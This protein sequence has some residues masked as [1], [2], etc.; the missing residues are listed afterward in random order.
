MLPGG[1]S[2][3]SLTAI[4]W[5]I[6][7]GRREP[8]C[9][10]FSMIR[11][12]YHLLAA[13]ISLTTL[14]AAQTL[15]PTKT[16]TLH[17]SKQTRSETV[18]A[19]TPDQALLAL[20]PQ[21]Q[22]RWKL[23]RLTGWNTSS[24]K[25]EAL[26][27]D[28]F[29]EEQRHTWGAGIGA[30]LIVSPDGHYVVTRIQTE[31]PGMLS[32]ARRNTDAIIHVVDLQTFKSVLT[33]ETTEPL[34]AGSIWS[35]TPEGNLISEIG[36]GNQ[37]KGRIDSISETA[38]ALSLPNLQASLTCHY[39]ENYGA[40]ETIG[41]ST[42]R[43]V[44]I[45]DVSQNC[46]ALMTLAKASDLKGLYHSNSTVT[47]VSKQLDFHPSGVS[48]TWNNQCGILDVSKQEKFVLYECVTGHQTWYDTV[49]STSRSYS[50]LSV[51]EAKQIGS[52]SVPPEKPVA[53][54]LSTVDGQDYLLILQNG[55]QLS[56]YSLL[57]VS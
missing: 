12:P 34:L 14:A 20:I 24:P 51:T 47:R 42:H 35:F 4:G 44:T 55:V 13:A 52:I 27:F 43:D 37:V 23:T 53:A 28:G 9:Y 16:Y 30:G 39:Q 10:Y 38:A 21:D 57:S 26:N 56:I 19:L 2:F 50:V 6:R 41:N 45:S 48:N 36:A 8:H 33:R 46:S 18:L 40:I 15:T 11:R 29:S 31:A 7:A 25:E 17:A 1:P 3:R 22:G 32:T 54:I 49:K 5:D